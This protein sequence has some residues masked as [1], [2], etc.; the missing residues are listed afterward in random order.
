MT[1][2]F[3]KC[4]FRVWKTGLMRRKKFT[5]SRLNS[6]KR[7]YFW[8]DTK[9]GKRT[10]SQLWYESLVSTQREKSTIHFDYSGPS[11]RSTF[12]PTY[13]AG[14]KYRFP[15][16]VQNTSILI[17]AQW[18]IFDISAQLV[19]HMDRLIS[20]SRFRQPIAGAIAC[21]FLL[22]PYNYL[23]AIRLHSS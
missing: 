7:I 2:T 16:L 19:I 13:A 5:H 9:N 3:K 1:V 11:L 18:S 10:A 6:V 14:K 8:K 17:L 23:F 15:S 22:L 4:V 21:S 12:F 20:R